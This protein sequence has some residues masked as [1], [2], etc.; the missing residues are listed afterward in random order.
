MLSYGGKATE[1]WNYGP[2]IVTK[3]HEEPGRER[4]A[5]VDILSGPAET[6]LALPNGPLLR[7]A[8][9]LACAGCLQLAQPLSSCLFGILIT[10]TLELGLQAGPLVGV[11]RLEI[12]SLELAVGRRLGRKQRRVGPADAKFDR[13]SRVG[14]DTGTRR[15]ANRGCPDFPV[16]RFEIVVNGSE[17]TAGRIARASGQ[18]QRKDNDSD[19]RQFWRQR[20]QAIQPQLRLRQLAAIICT[21]RPMRDRHADHSDFA[22][23]LFAAKLAQKR[24]DHGREI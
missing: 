19:G 12:G 2:D 17:I 14:V 22:R 20:Q 3:R 4:H 18:P 13:L 23:L 21:M 8:L 24:C 1:T 5:K 11:H 7:N 16:N 9:D 15:Q 6:V 10:L